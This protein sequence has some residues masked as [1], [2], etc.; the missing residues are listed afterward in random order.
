MLAPQGEQER[1]ESFTRGF[2][3][4][5]LPSRVHARPSASNANRWAVSSKT[6][7]P[8]LKT[9]DKAYVEHPVFEQLSEYAEFYGSLS[10]SIMSFVSMG[11]QSILN[12]DTYIY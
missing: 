3:F 1:A 9:M 6:K 5:L 2:K 4:F 12:I 7:A 11:T 10:F 8:K